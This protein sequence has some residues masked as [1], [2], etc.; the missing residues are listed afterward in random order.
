M[1]AV[2]TAHSGRRG[3]ARAPYVAGAL[4]L[5]AVTV[6]IFAGAGRL[7]SVVQ[8]ALG[9]SVIFFVGGLWWLASSLRRRSGSGGDPAHTAASTLNV[10]GIALVAALVGYYLLRDEGWAWL[11]S[12]LPA[13]ACAAGAWQVARR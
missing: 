5:A 3:S 4:A 1:N 10:Y 8:N 6:A 9:F 7:P 2:P 11:V 13:A 12:L